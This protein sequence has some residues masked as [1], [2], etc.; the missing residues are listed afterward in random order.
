MEKELAASFRPLL[1]EELTITFYDLTTV[2]IH[3]EKSFEGDIRVYGKSK[4]VGGVARQF[5][6]GFVQTADGLPLMHRVHPGNVA[7]TKTLQSVV[8]EVLERF[9]VKRLV[10]V[11]DRGLPSYDNIGELEKL[12]VRDGRKLE[13]VL[14]VPAR[15]YAQFAE[16]FG[17]IDEGKIGKVGKNGERL[18]EMEFAGNRLVVAH[19]PARAKERTEKRLERLG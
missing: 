4:D 19:D 9:P 8:S 11:A 3:G 13:V 10:L 1:D 5:T 7:E 16:A 18:A 6:L 15:R 14:A 2:R 12:S 17:K